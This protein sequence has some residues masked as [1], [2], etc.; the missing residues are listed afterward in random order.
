MADG[1]VRD[2]GQEV[3]MTTPIVRIRTPLAVVSALFLVAVGQ[4]IHF[5][6]RLPAVVVSHTGP[7]GPDGWM[8][9]GS[10][11]AVMLGMEGLLIIVIAVVPVVL[12]TLRGRRVRAIHSGSAASR[13]DDFSTDLYGQLGWLAVI[14]QAGNL[15]IWQYTLEENLGTG[16]LLPVGFLGLVGITVGAGLV[17]VAYFSRRLNR[18]ETDPLTF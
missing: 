5:Y 6:P 7:D 14:V 17:W 9:K 10:Y 13:G 8:S 12:S 2:D 4:A 18:R 3:V 15:L 1:R 11:L 16:H